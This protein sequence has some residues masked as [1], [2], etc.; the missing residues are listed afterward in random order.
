MLFDPHTGKYQ[1][2]RKGAR[3]PLDHRARGR[4]PPRGH[5]EDLRDRLEFYKTLLGKEPSLATANA[6]HARRKL[7]E[8]FRD[9]LASPRREFPDVSCSRTLWVHGFYNVI[10]NHRTQIRR[11]GRRISR[12]RGGATGAVGGANAAAAPA[13]QKLR[14]LRP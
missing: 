13:E 5:N 10:A 11:H 4:S 1:R 7:R 3:A 8:A 12:L 2:E 6:K 14:K 9:A